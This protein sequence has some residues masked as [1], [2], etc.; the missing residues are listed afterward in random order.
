MVSEGKD[1]RNRREPRTKTKL[2]IRDDIMVITKI[3]KDIMNMMLKNFTD[4]RKEGYWTIIR[5]LGGGGFC[6]RNGNNVRV[7]PFRRKG[8]RL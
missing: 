2:T 6:F 5:W 1:S 8:T 4:Y 7:F 3:K